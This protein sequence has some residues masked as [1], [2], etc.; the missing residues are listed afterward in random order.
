MNP[1][2][3]NVDASEVRKFDELAS[4]W[5]DPEGE[6]RPLHRLNPLRTQYVADRATIT[7][8]PVLDVGCG[9]GLLS[10]ALAQRGAHVTGIDMAPGPLQVARLHQ[11]KSGLESIRYLETNAEQLLPVGAWL[12]RQAGSKRERLASTAMLVA[13]GVPE[14]LLATM[15]LLALSV[16]WLQ[17]F[18]A[19]GLRSNG[20]EDWL[21]VWQVLDFVHH[22]ALPVLV[23]SIGPF[24]MVTRFVRDAVARAVAA[25]FS[26]S[27]HALGVDRAVVRR[28]LLRHGATPVATLAGGLLPMLVGGSIVVEN[29]FALDGLGHLAFEAVL[30]QDQAMVMAMVVLTSVVTLVSL[31]V[32]DLLHRVVDARVRLTG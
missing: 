30:A 6:F 12:G 24:V 26:A 25:P 13:I 7:E 2:G 3:N 1:A 16:A 29:L 9:G 23:I 21:F 5:W 8:Q 27:M 14:F 22:L 20:S 28:R 19:A 32:S 10:E 11:H 4:R 17:W 18:P 31:L 15:L